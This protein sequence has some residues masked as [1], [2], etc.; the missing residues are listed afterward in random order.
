MP[1]GWMCVD[2]LDA[3]D[4]MEISDIVIRPEVEAARVDPSQACEHGPPTAA[5]DPTPHTPPSLQTCSSAPS[6]V[7]TEPPETTCQAEGKECETYESAR[8]Q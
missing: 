5:A 1:V 4:T 2:E 6:P 8:D 3:V 7:E